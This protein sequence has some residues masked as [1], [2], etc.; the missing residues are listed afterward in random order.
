MDQWLSI[1]EVAERTGVAPS[2]LRFYE[3]EGLITAARS[4]GRQRRYARET[5]RRIAFIGAAQ[6]VG[7][8][9]DDIRSTLASLPEARTPTKA[10]WDRLS[11]SWRPLLDE[12]IARLERLRDELT[13]CIGCGC[14]SLRSCALYNPEDRAARRGA[15]P[16]YLLGDRPA[17]PV[18]PG[19]A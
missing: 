19:L 7:L 16:R 18:H 15:G 4:D 12:R 8:S 10:D 14:L 5:L 17:G 11:R 3:A 13:E 1:G 9:L 6:T 2:A